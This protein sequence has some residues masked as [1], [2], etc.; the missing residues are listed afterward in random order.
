M[1]P[2]VYFLSYH[3]Q[4]LSLHLISFK[5]IFQN[6]WTFCSI[7]W[8]FFLCF[9]VYLYCIYLLGT[10]ALAVPYILFIISKGLDF[11]SLLT[12][13]ESQERILP[14]S[15]PPF[16]HKWSS[17]TSLPFLYLL[18]HKVYT[19]IIMDYYFFLLTELIYG[20]FLNGVTALLSIKREL[21]IHKLYFICK[22]RN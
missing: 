9:R 10:F 4:R 2:E 15:V 19:F 7:V 13:V 12:I 3:C 21:N 17:D 14:N 16:S 20:R 8:F 11:I 1:Y 18:F 6:T 5:Y 22:I